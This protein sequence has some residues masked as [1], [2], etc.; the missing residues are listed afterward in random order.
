MRT[1]PVVLVAAAA[2]VA[3]C[4]PSN[5]TRD[6]KAEVEAANAAFSA[7]VAAQDAAA[8][9]RL[10]TED[11]WLM[12]PNGPTAKGRAA[13]AE[14]FTGMLGSGIAGVTLTTEE[15]QGTDSSATEVGRYA[16]TNAAGETVDEG[17]Y[18]VWWRRTADGWRLH[19]D[20]FNSDR[21]LPPPPAAPT[22]TKRR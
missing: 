2:L 16:L 3:A 6:V 7:A 17:K 14:A 12:A 13:I 5:T 9:S 21:P 8:V 22:A 15:A 20:I 18:L 19:R 10:Y 11:G 4:Q 1:R